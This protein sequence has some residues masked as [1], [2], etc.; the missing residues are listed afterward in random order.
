MGNAFFFKKKKQKIKTAMLSPYSTA[1]NF[2][3]QRSPKGTVM[4]SGVLI[5]LKTGFAGIDEKP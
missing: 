1:K 4:K 5:I 2:M 3:T